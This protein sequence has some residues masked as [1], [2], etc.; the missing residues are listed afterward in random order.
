MEYNAPLLST[1]YHTNKCTLKYNYVMESYRRWVCSALIPYFAEQSD[2]LVSPT[3]DKTTH[4]SAKQNKN[5][6]PSTNSTK[7]SNS[8]NGGTG[9]D[10]QLKRTSES[11]NEANHFVI[12]EPT[13]KR[14]KRSQT[15]NNETT[16][17]ITL[18]DVIDIDSYDNSDNN[19]NNYKNK[20]NS[21]TASHRR[22]RNSDTRCNRELQQKILLHQL[23]QKQDYNNDS[24]DF[25]STAN[26][27]DP[28][29]ED[30]VI[31]K[32]LK[33]SKRKVEF[34]KRRR[35]RPCLSICQTVEQK[36]PYLLPADRAPA[37]PTQ[38]AGEPTFLCLDQNIPETG[39]QLHKS[40][41]GPPDCCYTYCDSAMDGI[42]TYCDEFAAFAESEHETSANATRQVHNITLTARTQHRIDTRLGAA[43][44]LVNETKA[45]TASVAIALKNVTTAMSSMTLEHL[46]YYAHYEGTYYYDDDPNDM[47][48]E[49]ISGNCPTVP[50]VSSRCTI[51]YF[52]SAAAT[53]RPKSQR[54]LFAQQ[55]LLWFSALLCLLSSCNAAQQIKQVCRT[56]AQP[57]ITKEMPTVACK[58]CM[59]ADSTFATGELFNRELNSCAT[60]ISALATFRPT[61]PLHQRLSSGISSKNHNH[62]KCNRPSMHVLKRLRKPV[63][64]IKKFIFKFSNVNFSSTM[65]FYR[66][67][68]SS[69]KLS[70]CNITINT[71][72]KYKYKYK[73][74]KILIIE[75]HK[76]K[77]NN[78]T[79]NKN[80]RSFYYYNFNINDWWRRWWIRAPTLHKKSRLRTS[81]S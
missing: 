61:H 45:R 71:Y 18:L 27:E 41:Y 19:N 68:N 37:L 52:A 30:P 62:A 39:E 32:L 77:I 49:A 3:T 7:T 5:S 17:K 1:S 31:S 74:I 10:Q 12:N 2:I 63:Q 42:C 75:G 28:C 20:D 67:E 56:R 64:N 24:N 58:C 53:H 51:P 11:L 9:K 25:I 44:A 47:P 16:A 6:V 79:I 55:L 46:P 80:Y 13:V 40:S 34:R 29:A 22:K 48:N 59:K 57:K 33:R 66:S 36:C 73:N 26:S 60:Y 76:E 81:T 65:K 14:S 15:G 35:I 54:A 4:S 72:S 50:S 23:S 43:L 69:R 78:C 8:T 38:Y 21:M 70:T